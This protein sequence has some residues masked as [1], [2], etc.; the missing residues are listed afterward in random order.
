VSDKQVAIPVWL[1]PVGHFHDASFQWAS[2]VLQKAVEAPLPDDERRTVGLYRKALTCISALE[3]GRRFPSLPVHVW[4]WTDPEWG[5][6][7]SLGPFTGICLKRCSLPLLRDLQ[8]LVRVRDLA[9]IRMQE[10]GVTNEWRDPAKLA[11]IPQ[12]GKPE[13]VS[14]RTV[15]GGLPTL[16]RGH[17]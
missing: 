1:K 17:R 9:E 7:A 10:L 13:R 6:V 4:T 15:P 11:R 12:E 5:P 3:R 2:G 8:F 16:G 14:I